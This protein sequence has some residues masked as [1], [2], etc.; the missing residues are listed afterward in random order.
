MKAFLHKLKND[1][2]GVA[3]EMAITL[4]VVTFALS[5]LV[6]STSLLQHS[7]KVKAENEMPRTAVLEQIGEAF[8]AN[9]AAGKAP[10]QWSGA[11]P[12][13]KITVEGLTL[14]V[15]ERD[16]DTVLLTV[17]LQQNG[18]DFTVIQWSYN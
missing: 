9:T 13:Y 17:V 6:L 18:T 14:T 4:L 11:Y 7:K 5:T 8:C 3:L 1:R 16:S 10:S 2:R 12:D 15:S